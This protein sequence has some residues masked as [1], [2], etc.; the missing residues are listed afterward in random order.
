MIESVTEPD[1]RSWALARATGEARRHSP[2]RHLPGQHPLAHRKLGSGVGPAPA[3]AL[4]GPTQ[5]HRT[6]QM[7]VSGVGRGMPMPLPHTEKV[8]SSPGPRRWAPRPGRCRVGRTSARWRSGSAGAVSAAGGRQA[9]PAALRARPWPVVGI[10]PQSS[11]NVRRTS[12][13]P[14]VTTPQSRSDASPR[15]HGTGKQDERPQATRQPGNNRDPARDR[16]EHGGGHRINGTSGRP[17]RPATRRRGRAAAFDRARHTRA[18]VC[19]TPGVAVAEY[20]DKAASVAALKGV[21]MLF[22]VS[23]QENP[24]RVTEH[25]TFIDAAA[26]AGVANVLYLSFFG[27]RPDATFLL[28]SRSLGYGAVF[29]YQWNGLRCLPGQSLRGF[30]PTIC[31]A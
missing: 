21:E 20:R 13:S 26:A 1:S 12:R 25:R 19:R 18:P 15:W 8:H 5:V 22:M 6:T 7:W 17:G 11:H 29:A 3:M 10:I 28:A 31:P 24:E 30:H 9:P 16:H 14:Y 23:A 2:D 4:P 27:A